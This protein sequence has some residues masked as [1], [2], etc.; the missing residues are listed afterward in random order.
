MPFVIITVP[1]RTGQLE[2]AQR[3]LLAGTWPALRNWQQTLRCRFQVSLADGRM[4][5]ATGK[6][7]I[8]REP[9]AFSDLQFACSAPAA[10]HA[11]HRTSK[12]FAGLS[13]P[14]APPWS[15]APSKILRCVPKYRE[16]TSSSQPVCPPKRGVCSKGPRPLENL[17][18][19]CQP[20]RSHT[21]ELTPSSM[22]I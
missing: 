13:P 9:F 18:E 5:K 14:S 12:M 19:S 6:S 17:D 22:W 20:N 7:R 8:A 10:Q 3:Y 15:C 4:H 1:P 2:V 16:P 11:G 21:Q